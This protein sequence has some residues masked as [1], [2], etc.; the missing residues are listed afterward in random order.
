M[1]NLGNMKRVSRLKR[2]FSPELRRKIVKDIEDGKASI[3]SVRREYS[4]ANTTVYRWIHTDSTYLQ[5][6]V[7]VVL[8][9]SSEG[10]RSKELEKKLKEAEAALGRKQM[11]VDFLEKMI[12]MAGKEF[13]IDIKK[14]SP[15]LPSTG[16]EPIRKKG[17]TK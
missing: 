2:V 14:K 8:E 1:V 3:A 4:V 7:K 11:E 13:G 5:K 6:G 15:T 9:L 10:Y 12:E 17:R 16:S